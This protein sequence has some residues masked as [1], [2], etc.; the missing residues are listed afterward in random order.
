M[1]DKVVF[2]FGRFNPPTT[3]HEKLLDKVFAVAKKEGADFLVFPSHSQNPKKDPL[4][5][6]SKV[7]FMKKMF[8]KYSKNIMSNNKVKTAFN[9]VSL[10]HDLGYKQAIMVVGGDRVSEFDNVLNKYNGVEGRHGFYEFEGGV[11]I[12][13]AGERDPDAEG[14]SGMSASKMRAAA[15]AN[16]YDSFKNGLPSKFRGGE[17]LFKM[18]RKAMKVEDTELGIFLGSDVNTFREFVDSPTVESIEVFDDKE[19]IQEFYVPVELQKRESSISGFKS[20]LS[21]EKLDELVSQKQIDDLEKFADKLLKKYQID[22]EFTRHFVDRIN[23]KRNTPEIK[24]AEL[25]KIFKKIKNNK[26]N[27][28]KSNA[29][30]QAIIKDIS[31]YLNIPVVI[32]KDKD[33]EIELTAKTIM[34]KKNFTS[35]NSVLKYEDIEEDFTNI[36]WIDDTLDRLF[37]KSKYKMALQYFF[38]FYEKDPKH[39]SRNAL[40]RASKVLGLEPL[41]LQKYVISLIKKGKIPKKYSF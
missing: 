34:R 41:P 1:K 36:P 13:S 7:K 26:G 38:K 32:K 30:D 40:D 18:L 2:T 6:R 29:D 16:D 24:V 25:Q 3:G 23:D 14:V 8:P 31:S 22:V 35:S 17:L 28:I 39:S 4:D 15:A 9:A 37:R 11:K 20:F 27:Q 5:F 19:L 21:E 33:G 10:I 12:V